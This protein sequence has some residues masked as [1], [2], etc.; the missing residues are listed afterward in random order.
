[1]SSFRKMYRIHHIID[2]YFS[3]FF[4]KHNKKLIYIVLNV[5][6]VKSQIMLPF[7]LFSMRRADSLEKTLMLGKAEVK[8][9]RERA[10]E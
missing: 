1:M 4:L 3:H 9:R 5:I 6:M 7:P 2:A 8:R 10:E